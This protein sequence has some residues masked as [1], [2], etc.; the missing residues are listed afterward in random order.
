MLQEVV[1]DK[2]VSTGNTEIDKKIGGGIPVGT[3]T[4][5]EGDSDAGKSVLTQQMAWG[6]LS[7]GKRVTV[8]TTENTT[9]SLLR[10]MESIGLDVTDYFIM[11]RLKIF[12]LPVRGIQPHEVFERLLAHVGSHE[13]D[14]VIIDS[15]TPFVSHGDTQEVLRFMT[16][17]KAECDTGMSIIA[18]VHANVVDEGTMVR[19]RSTSDAHLRLRLEEAGDKLIKMLEVAKVRGAA[20]STGNIIGFN[21]EPGIGMRMI[22]V[23]KAKA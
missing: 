16:E 8:Y 23:A 5:V 4:L 3:L 10:Q 7:Q 13:T 6:A 21:V 22:A 17:I 18:V 9:R 11:S 19:L 15:L 12:A 14:I 2:I 1:N 20:K